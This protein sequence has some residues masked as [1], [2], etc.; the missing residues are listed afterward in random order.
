M[1]GYLENYGAG[2]ERREKITKTVLVAV[3]AAL[4]IGG[5]GYLFFRNFPEERQARR[6][7]ELLQAHNYKEA[8]ALW[9]CTDAKPCR[10]YNETE[11]L[12]DWGPSQAPVNEIDVLDTE[13]CGSG[14]IVEVDA[15]KAGDKKLWVE[16]DTKILGF[17]PFE[18]CP[19]GNRIHDFWRNI[20]FRLHG[21]PVPPE[22]S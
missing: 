4:I 21:R 22:G 17:P 6:F 7:F 18:R 10:D 3:A 14:V 5:L 19:Q 15:G 16:R 9:G 8:Y 12:K 11:F 2:E 13:S 20:K 1:A